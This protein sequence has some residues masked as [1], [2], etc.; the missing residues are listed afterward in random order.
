MKKIQIEAARIATGA[1]KLVSIA[2]LYRETRWD[3]LDER[4]RKHKLTLLYKMTN[5]LSPLY[6]S[7]L[8][9]QTVSNA[10]RYNLRNSSDLQTVEAR[11][12]LFYNS[13]LPSTVRAW[14]SLSST[15][16]QPD[17]TY[18]FKYFLN[19][20]KDSTPKYYYA[21]SRKAQIFHTRLRTVCS[22]LKLD[23]FLKNM[24]DSLIC[25]CGSV[26][27]AQHFFFHCG[28][29][30]LHRTLLLDT[31]SQYQNPSLNIL[32]YGDKA[33]SPGINTII[34]EKVQAFIL[35]TKRFQP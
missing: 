33:L 3:S 20:D 13:F 19:K 9:P 34:F 23:L 22:S 30:Q 5:A 14:N 17:S 28:N 8:V 6:L 12:S 24:F 35:Q 11:T 1:T 29:Y 15:A 4:H 7:S 21:G 32:L 10:S 18:S 27:D 2:A 25:L 16:K 31:I 26:E